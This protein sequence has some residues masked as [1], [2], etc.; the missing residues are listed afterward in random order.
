MPRSPNPPVFRALLAAAAAILVATGVTLFASVTPA[1]AHGVTMMPGS[2]T[3][4][5]YLDGLTDTGEIKP[6]N[7]A[8]ADAVADG[9][10]TPLYN[11]F[12]VLDSNAAGRNVGYV[13]DGTICSAGDKSPY[14][15]AAYN[16]ARADWPITHLTSGASIEVRHSNWAAHPGAF[17]MYITKPGWD[18]TRPLAWSDLEPFWSA[19]DPP[20]SGGP[21]GFNYYHWDVDLPQRSGQHLIFTQWVRSDSAENFFSCADVVFDGGDGEVTGI[22]TEVDSVTAMSWTASGHDHAG[23][24]DASAATPAPARGSLWTSL[25]PVGAIIAFA[26]LAAV[27]ASLR[28]RRRREA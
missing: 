10:A 25:W 3:Y 19:T 14:D 24:G 7:P 21:G 16:Q 15:F 9:G 12:A 1:S 28:A 20:Q 4:L 17:H 11:W 6:E 5:C 26:L 13:P 23:T 27:V 8:C 2:R 22:D 18:P